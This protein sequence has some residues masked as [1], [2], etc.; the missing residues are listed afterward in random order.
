MR[1]RIGARQPTRHDDKNS[2]IYASIMLFVCC[3]DAD[4]TSP[5]ACKRNQPSGWRVQSS[6]LAKLVAA[7]GVIAWC[8]TEFEH[9]I[10]SYSETQQMRGDL[11]DAFVQGSVFEECHGMYYMKHGAL[12]IEGLFL[13]HPGIFVS[14]SSRPTSKPFQIIAEVDWSTV[15]R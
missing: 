8:V 10:V 7:G 9:C 5:H 13:M 15:I 14:I 2:H 12:D 11:D 4:R 6:I 3:Y 1:L